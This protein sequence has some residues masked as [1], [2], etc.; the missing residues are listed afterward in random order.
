MWMQPYLSPFLSMLFAVD[1]V[2][3]HTYL[4]IKFSH[5]LKW[6]QHIQDISVIEGSKASESH[7]PIKIQTRQE[8]I[9]NHV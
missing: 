8:N 1:D 9:Q 4:G 2:L 3:H 6:S 7:G 5:N